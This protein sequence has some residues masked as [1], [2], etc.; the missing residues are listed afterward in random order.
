M[1]HTFNLKIC[2]RVTL[3]SDTGHKQTWEKGL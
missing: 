2:A 3:I 1:L